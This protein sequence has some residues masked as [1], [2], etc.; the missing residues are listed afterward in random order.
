[1]SST[2]RILTVILLAT[3][4]SSVNLWAQ[5]DNE[6]GKQTQTKKKRLVKGAKKKRDY[7]SAE[8]DLNIGWDSNIF[9]TP[10]KQYIDP[11]TGNPASN[12]AQTGQV[13]NPDVT[14][15]YAAVDK[16]KFELDFN[17]D[18]DGNY[19]YGAKNASNANGNDQS[20]EAKTRFTFI[21][22][23]KAAIERLQLRAAYYYSIHDY[24]YYHRGTGL[25]RTTSSLMLEEDRYNRSETGIKLEPKFK[26]SSDTTVSLPFKFYKRDYDEVGTL[27]SYDR[28]GAVYEIEIE[29]RIGAH[30]SINAMANQEAIE[31]DSHRAF[32]ATGTTVPG[33]SRKY[34]DQEVLLGLDYETERYFGGL[35]Y[36]TLERD[37]EFAG[38]WSYSQDKTAIE[39]GLFLNKKS[40][41][42]V[43]GSV[44]NRDYDKET[45][46]SGE[47][48]SRSFKSLA[49]SY[50]YKRKA[51]KLNLDVVHSIQ[52]DTD[53]YYEYEKSLILIGYNREF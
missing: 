30:W 29:Q 21:D 12:T 35:S 38:Y 22:N 32:D 39:A 10:S 28:T 37:D 33:T 6:P 20:L 17:Y 52:G 44:M 40:S 46:P 14:F 51:D 25:K 9:K 4:L 23:K 24:L 8:L 47:I 5:D 50:E 49:L 15:T 13:V 19:Y 16:K 27:Q 36:R 42:S 34:T 43:E 45:A 18:Y 41:L 31:Y 11:T 7:L 48:R 26:F 1:M 3:L 53:K 2:L